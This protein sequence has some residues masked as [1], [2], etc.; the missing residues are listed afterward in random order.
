[1][2]EYIVNLWDKLSK[3]LTSKLLPCILLALIGIVVVRLLLKFVDRLLARTK[4][5]PAAARLV[6]SILQAVLYL[7]VFLIAAPVIGVD[8]TSLVALT[9]VVT[10]AISL[11]LQN[12]LT[13]VIGGFNLLYTKPFVVGDFVE[14][15]TKS[16]TVLEVGLTYTRLRTGDNKIISI[17]NSAVVATDIVNY[18]AAGTRRVDITVTASYDAPAATVKEALLKAAQVPGVLED[19]APMAALESYGDSA[20]GYV[21]KVWCPVEIYYDTLYQI[22]ENIKLRFDEA[23]VEMTYPHLN[24]HLDK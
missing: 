16:G 5:E 10:L 18:S 12:A 4:L 13:N 24:V 1:M 21:L 19:P 8:V 20:I 15:A 7:L 14:I 3:F 6:R 22:N 23:G 17:P 11:S 9:S 2:P